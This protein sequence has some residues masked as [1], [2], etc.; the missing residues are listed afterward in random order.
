MTWFRVLITSVLFS[1]A[2]ESIS[3]TALAQSGTTPCEDSCKDKCKKGGDSCKKD[4]DRLK[5]L[6]TYTGRSAFC[7]AA[8]DRGC[9]ASQDYCESMCFV[10]FSGPAQTCE[11]PAPEPPKPKPGGTSG[12]PHLVT[13]DGQYYDFQ[14]AGDFL[15]TETVDGEVAI[16]IRQT[17]YTSKASINTAFGIRI[18]E[19]VLRYDLREPRWQ[20]DRNGETVPFELLLDGSVDGVSV[21]LDGPKNILIAKPGIVAIHVNLRPEFRLDLYV[22]YLAEQPTR[23]LLGD[24]DGDPNNDVPLPA[25]AEIRTWVNTEF[26]DKWRLSDAE[27]LLPYA[28]GE[29]VA[30]FTLRPHP[31]EPAL[32]SSVEM[33]AAYETCKQADVPSSQMASCAHDVA[34]TGEDRFAEGWIDVPRADIVWS[35]DGQPTLVSQIAEVIHQA[36][37]ETDGAEAE[38]LAPDNETPWETRIWIIY[39]ADQF[40]ADWQSTFLPLCRANALQTDTSCQCAL[41]LISSDESGADETVRARVAYLFTREEVATNSNALDALRSYSRRTNGPQSAATENPLIISDYRLYLSVK[42]LCVGAGQ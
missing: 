3:F 38:G 35:I 25:G 8:K 26:A 31:S 20:V 1:L 37:A 18:G 11:P 5:R 17:A 41:E 10:D 7:D 12:E 39:E 22:T 19:I 33:R 23:G 24:S 14:A 16:H 21:R 40:D 30:D 42:D 2:F 27:S 6:C 32:L 4:I 36:S 29:T 34:I 28:A 13:I 15:L 9:K